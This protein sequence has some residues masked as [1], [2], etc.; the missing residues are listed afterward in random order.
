MAKIDECE[1]FA[2]SGKCHE[3]MINFFKVKYLDNRDNV[4]E[5]ELQ[6]A[7]EICSNC[8]N[9]KKKNGKKTFS[10]TQELLLKG[11]IVSS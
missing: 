1:N 6:K 4:T 10:A 2:A 5:A 11:K 8:P 3:W 7:D 9:F